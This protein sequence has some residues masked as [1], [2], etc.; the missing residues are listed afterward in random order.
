VLEKGATGGDV[1]LPPGRRWLDWWTLQPAE[2]G[3][4][5]VPWDF[6]PVYLAEGSIVP[7]LVEIPDTAVEAADAALTTLSEVDDQRRV[8]IFGAGGS[9][10]EADGTRYTLQGTPS[11]PA[12]LAFTGASGVVNLGGARLV[13]EGTV[14]RAYSLVLVP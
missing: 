4:V 2:S 5:D 14:E 1:A 3:F 13:I 8:F 12:E 9:F 7:T 10:V 6:I 11:A